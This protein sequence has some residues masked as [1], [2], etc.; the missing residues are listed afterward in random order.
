MAPAASQPTDPT[1]VAYA[2]NLMDRSRIEVA[3]TAA[4]F[5]LCFV[6]DP[7]HLG[8]AI[9]AGARV[10]VVDLAGEGVLAALP[11]LTR[12][13]T[14]GFASHVDTALRAAAR[15]AG[16][17]EVV[18]RSAL[19]RRLARIGSGQGPEVPGA[20][21]GAVDSRVTSTATSSVWEDPPPSTDPRP[22]ETSP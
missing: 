4:G 13:Q 20:S 12:A 21:E 22:G 8:P 5:V 14:I 3:A 6:T 18:P 11:S 7:G 17:D 2:P 19:V 15:A 1:V 9:E 16:C 10:A